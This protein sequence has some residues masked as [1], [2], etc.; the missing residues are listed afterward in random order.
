MTS[1]IC[2]PV[3]VRFQDAGI[4]SVASSVRRAKSSSSIRCCVPMRVARSLPER[5]QRRT[6]S[7]SRLVRRAAS[8]TVSIVAKYYNNSTIVAQQHL[9][10][11]MVFDATQRN[12]ANSDRH[13]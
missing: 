2:S 1:G 10:E 13:F 5:I 8:G 7:G 3:A 12:S 6:V 4:G 9:C 11:T